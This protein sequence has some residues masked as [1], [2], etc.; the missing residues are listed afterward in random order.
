MSARMV[1]KKKTEAI[2]KAIGV[3]LAFNAIALIGAYIAWLGF[4]SPVGRWLEL[5][6]PTKPYVPG[7]L[8]VLQIF[9][10]MIAYYYYR[11]KVKRG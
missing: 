2:L 11:D 10:L 5:N 6:K 4:T 9:P 8:F 7:T 3:Y 1:V